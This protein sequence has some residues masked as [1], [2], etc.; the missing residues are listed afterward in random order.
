MSENRFRS[1]TDAPVT[2]SGPTN[3]RAPGSGLGLLRRKLTDSAAV[4]VGA[5]LAS[6]VLA[7]SP[8]SAQDDTLGAGRTVAENSSVTGRPVNQNTV[9]ALLGGEELTEREQQYEEYLFKYESREYEEAL[10]PATRVV[11]LTERE[12]GRDTPLLTDPL[13]NLATLQSMTD[14]PTEAVANYQR[15]IELIEENYSENDPRLV[16]PLT[17]LGEIHNA[18]GHYEEA[19]PYL[20]RAQHITRR[21]DGLYNLEQVK[22]LEQMAIS[23]HGLEDIRMSVTKQASAYQIYQRQFGANSPEILPALYN[24]AE[25]L[26]KIFSTRDSYDR[27]RLTCLVERKVTW[28]ADEKQICPVPGERDL[29]RKAVHIVEDTYGPEDIRLVEPL[30]RLAESY[31]H[32]SVVSVG[33]Q[34]VRQD[35]RAKTYLYRA[36]EIIDQ[37]DDV[38]PVLHASALVALGDWYLRFSPVWEKGIQYYDLA[39]R[40]LTPDG[41]RTPESDRFFKDPHLVFMPAIRPAVR[42]QN[43]QFASI[44]QLGSGYVVVSYDVDPEGWAHNVEVLQTEPDDYRRQQNYVARAVKLARFRP[45]YKE[46]QRDWAHNQRLRHDFFYME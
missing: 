14:Q 34:Y 28:E 11:D 3:S 24:L 1:R 33:G 22:Q 30:V 26:G 13:I 43:G 4:R 38:D 42:R 8:A 29:Y 9:G 6:A 25:H 40:I 27:V 37:N 46:G 7:W 20:E 12:A 32:K 18:V 2:C 17:A 23:Y 10:E 16:R 36:L 45:T 41:S 39:W 19:I 15:S 31:R 5:L 44:G 21:H 35:P